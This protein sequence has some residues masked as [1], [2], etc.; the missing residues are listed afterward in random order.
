MLADTNTF[1]QLFSINSNPHRMQC[2]TRFGPRS[3]SFPVIHCWSAATDRGSPSSATPLCRR[4]A[5]LWFLST[6]CFSGWIRRDLS[7]VCTDEDA[8]CMRSNQLLLNTTKTEIIWSTT[9]HRLQQLPQLLLRVSPN[10]IVPAT[11]IRD[12]WIYLDSD[13][14]MRSHVAKTVSS[15]F[16]VVHQLRC[17]RRSVTRSVLQSLASSLIC[18]RLDYGN[19]TLAGIQYHRCFCHGLSQWWK[20]LLLLGSSFLLR[21]STTSLRSSASST[22]WR[23]H[24]KCAVAS[25]YTDAFTGLHRRTSSMNCRVA[26]VKARQRLHSASSSSLTVGRTQLSTVRDRA[27]PVASARISNSL[28]PSR[29]FCTLLLVFRSSLE[30]RLFTNSYPSPWPCTVLAVTRHFGQLPYLLTYLPVNW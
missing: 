27:F 23:P 22:G 3:N 8:S 7:P 28:P 25:L 10:Q 18:P 4:H 24:S 1:G 12:L 29:H 19:A 14:S 20:L 9:C 21:G 5:N 26:D 16:A 15:C 11:V 30:T 6:I 13:V 17:I 2:A